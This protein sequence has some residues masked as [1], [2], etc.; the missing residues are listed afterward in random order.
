MVGQHYSSGETE[1]LRRESCGVQRKARLSQ[2]PHSSRTR[3]EPAIRFV[4]TCDNASEWSTD[5][6]W[7]KLDQYS[8]FKSR[9]DNHRAKAQAAA[10]IVEVESDA[11]ADVVDVK[12]SEDRSN[13]IRQFFTD[14]GRTFVTCSAI[15]DCQETVLNPGKYWKCM[16]CHKEY[17]QA[18]NL[19]ATSRNIL[20][21]CQSQ[22]SAMH[23]ASMDS[24]SSNFSHLKGICCP[25]IIGCIGLLTQPCLQKLIVRGSSALRQSLIG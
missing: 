16:L 20:Q 8:K 22:L 7:M 6:L 18:G 25:F 9:F 24:I 5:S 21:T 1:T 19:L 15:K 4:L 14:T 13:T 11:G 3:T 10:E 23:M 2:V 12:Q 17:K